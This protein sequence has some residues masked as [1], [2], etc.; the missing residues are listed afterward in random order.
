MEITSHRLDVP[1]FAERLLRRQR[2]RLAWVLA[3]QIALCAGLLY[4]MRALRVV[5]VESLVVSVPLVLVV[6]GIRVLV[7]LRKQR[8]QIAACESY[9]LVLGEHVM[10]R[11]QDGL[12]AVELLR[13]EVAHIFDTPSEGLLVTTADARRFIFIPREL[14]GIDKV[15]ERLSSWAAFEV[16]VQPPLL[17]AKVLG[18]ALLLPVL[19]LGSGFIPNIYLALAVGA[20]LIVLGTIRIVSVARLPIVGVD[21]KVRFIGALLFMM[22]SPFARAILHFGFHMEVKWPT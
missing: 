1:A 15:R 20:V 2:R 18:S 13:S 10:R 4:A 14:I 21:R 16:P 17:R 8:G 5:S 22:L 6:L 11:S 3:L 19:W 12:P 9:Q 7:L